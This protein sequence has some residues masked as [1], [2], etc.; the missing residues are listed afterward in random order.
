MTYN[1]HKGKNA[2]GRPYSIKNLNKILSQESY[3][4][5]LF[6][7]VL[8]N[9][10][11][12]NNIRAQ[13]ELLAKK[14]FY[15]HAF[16]KNSVVKGFD[17]GNSIVSKYQIIEENILNLTLHR[18]EKRSALLSLID[19][20]KFKI[21]FICTHL[22]LRKTDRVRQAKMLLHFIKKNE[23]EGVP[24]ILGGDFNDR[25]GEVLKFFLGEGGFSTLSNSHS[26]LTFPSVL[27]VFSFDRILSK[28]L[29]VIDCK[30]GSSKTYNSF[31]DHLPLFC[32]FKVNK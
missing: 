11:F 32:T 30:V 22:N 6:Q 4:I 1:L 26:L 12:D 27:P 14:S 18:F 15:E 29:T 20:G 7:E 21:Q 24:I 10:Q 16:A 17:H 19:F 2:L 31:S 23:I 5:A 9:N 8:G 13:S 28:N 3:D 25:N